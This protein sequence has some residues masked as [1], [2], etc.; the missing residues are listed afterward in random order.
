M[1]ID[2]ACRR[3]PVTGN[4]GRSKGGLVLRALRYHAAPGLTSQAIC[5][6][7]Y[8]IVVALLDTEKELGESDRDA[9][10]Q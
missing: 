8:Y 1:R 3:K 2:L 6:V 5:K 7:A 4:Q 9:F 10:S